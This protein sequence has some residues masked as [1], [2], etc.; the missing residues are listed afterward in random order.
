MANVE[1]VVTEA[2][3]L[4][5]CPAWCPTE[6]VLYWIDIDGKAVHRYDPSTGEDQVRSTPGRP[7]SFALTQTPGVLLLATEH[8]V[9]WFDW[10]SGTITPWVDLEEPK[11]GIRLNDGRTDPAGRFVVGSMFEDTEALKRVGSLHRVDADG[12]TH[13]L[14]SQVGVTNGIGFDPDRGRMYFADSPTERVICWDYDLGTAAM[15]A[16]REF[17]D[18][19]T[20]DGFP[21]GACVDADGCYWSASV[22]GWALTRITP[23]GVVDLQI[24]LPVYK[25]TM[26]AF[27]GPGM[28]TIFVT[29]IAGRVPDESRTGGVA[30]GVVLAVDV[31]GT[32]ITGRAEVPFAGS[33][34]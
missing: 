11:V 18:Y 30:G 32:G 14:R 23:D 29:S 15:S 31:S 34:P 25:P 13:R 3:E 9:V 26:P 7:G 28:D 24:D 21:D 8:E 22:Y 33:A 27:G 1:V 20:I 5:E 16:E 19:A 6:S 2:A 17:F 12:S 4:G 10:A